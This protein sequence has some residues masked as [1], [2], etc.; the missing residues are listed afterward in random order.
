MKKAQIDRA[1]PFESTAWRLGPAVW[2][3]ELVK[4]ISKQ[5]P[6]TGRRA[7]FR[8]LIDPASNPASTDMTG[9]TTQISPIRA[10]AA[11]GTR[12]SDPG[13]RAR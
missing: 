8:D 4:A 9:S 13:F 10:M 12:Q 5:R 1:W 11:C 6:E 7:S 3:T 2:L